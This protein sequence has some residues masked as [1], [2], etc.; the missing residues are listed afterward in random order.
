MHELHTRGPADTA[1]A[2]EKRFPDQITSLPARPKIAWESHQLAESEAYQRLG[3]PTQPCQ[4]AACI[5]PKQR[6]R[7]SQAYLDR[8]WR[9]VGRQLAT[10]GYRL[11]ALLNS[12][13]EH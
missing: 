12:V 5:T 2:L 10:G 11:A 13:W 4:P 6:V 3:I 1:A 9:V 7:V 8:E